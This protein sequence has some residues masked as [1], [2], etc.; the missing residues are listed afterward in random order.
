MKLR[1]REIREAKGVTQEQLAR[2]VNTTNASISRMESGGIAG[3]DKLE[4]IAAVLGVTVL[5]LISP[6]PR[7]DLLISFERFFLALPVEQQK[8]LLETARALHNARQA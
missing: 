5:D 4:R 2:A 3:L 8:A 7:P 6:D 1:V